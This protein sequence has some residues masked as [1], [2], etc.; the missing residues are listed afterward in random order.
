M[1]LVV[2]EPIQAMPAKH[3]DDQMMPV[4]DECRPGARAAA[5]DV[6]KFHMCIS[7]RFRPVHPPLTFSL[8]LSAQA[9]HPHPCQLTRKMLPQ[10][11]ATEARFHYEI[12]L[13]AYP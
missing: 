12:D 1:F 2:A 4:K 13:T 10:T 8:I 3:R 6:A 9:C 5:P 7:V 11:T